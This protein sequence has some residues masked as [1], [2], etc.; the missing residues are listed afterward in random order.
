MTKI[1]LEHF[2]WIPVIQPYEDYG[3]QK[4]GSEARRSSSDEIRRIPCRSRR[5]TG[6]PRRPCAMVAWSRRL[7]RT[8]EIHAAWLGDHD[9]D[10]RRQPSSSVAGSSDRHTTTADDRPVSAAR[11]RAA[12]AERVEPSRHARKISLARGVLRRQGSARIPTAHDAPRWTSHRAGETGS[13]RRRRACAMGRSLDG[14][15]PD[16][17]Y[18]RRT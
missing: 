9:A 4:Y 17:V 6:R 5:P 13:R 8:A 15:R 1:F 14:V 10:E 11:C 16:A 18:A 2:P 12:T 3:L 7:R